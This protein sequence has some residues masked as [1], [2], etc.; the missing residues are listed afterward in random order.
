L[1]SLAPD[2][3]ILALP[4]KSAIFK[5]RLK[6]GPDVLKELAN[7]ALKPIAP[8]NAPEAWYKG[9]RL[10]SLDGSVFDVPD[11]TENATYFGYL[12]SSRGETAFPQLR[13]LS[14]IETGSQVAGAGEVGQSKRSEQELTSILIDQEKFSP[15]MLALAD[16]NFYGYN[17]WKKACNTGANL[18]W[19]IKNNLNL[20]IKKRLPDKSFLS[21][22]YDSRDKKNCIPIQVRVIEYKLKDNNGQDNDIIYRIITNVLDYILAPAN[23]LAALYHERWEIE[24]V[25]GEIKVVLKGNSTIIRSKFQI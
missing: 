7:R 10:M 24:N 1:S 3:N 13:L 14:L 12:S 19:R 15:E 4:T 25:Y 5:A 20:P 16:R 18:F 21:T 8:L 9:M 22:V 23:E 11:S 2:F 17:L 6:L